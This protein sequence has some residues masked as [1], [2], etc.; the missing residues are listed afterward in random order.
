[1]V[2]TAGTGARD[3]SPAGARVFQQDEVV[4]AWVH[5]GAVERAA[6]WRASAHS[7]VDWSETKT[8]GLV[9]PRDFSDS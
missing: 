4:C 3:A 9:L 5:R 8:Y 7:N 6:D 2:R 1:M